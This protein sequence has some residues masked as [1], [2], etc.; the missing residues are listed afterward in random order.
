MKK[1]ITFVCNGNIERSVVAEHSLKNILKKNILDSKFIVNS[2]G[3]QGTKGTN[4]PKYKKLSHYPKESQASKPALQEFGIDINDHS[5]QKI[6]L[7]V[8]EKASVVIAMDNN[9]FSGAKN[10]LLKQFPKHKK[11]IYYF[12]K[13][14]KNHKQIKDPAGSGSKDLHRKVIRDINLALTNNYEIILSWIKVDPFL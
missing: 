7:G 12:S 10:S 9:V 11:K 4:L 2:Y 6:T 14:T 1:I 13:L 3:L 5:F 8:V